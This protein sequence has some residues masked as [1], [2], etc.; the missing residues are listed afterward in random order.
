MVH[1]TR[2]IVK[3]PNSGMPYQNPYLPVANKA[4]SQIRGFLSDFGMSPTA[5]V[6]IPSQKPTKK[7]E[8]DSIRGFLARGRSLKNG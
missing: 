1:K 3:T 4:M 7:D 2:P 8:D 6:S 5:R